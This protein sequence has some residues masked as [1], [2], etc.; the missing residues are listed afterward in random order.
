MVRPPVSEEIA[1][2]VARF[3][4]GGAGPTHT[5][6]T[7]A[8]RV[9]GYVDADPWDPVM[10]T[11]SKEIRVVT[12]IRAATR[13]PIRARELM[14]ALLRDLRAD[15]HFDDGTVTV[16][17]L[18]RAQA[19]FA[20]QEWNLSDQGHLTQKGPINLD[21]GGRPA[22]DEQLRRLQRAGDDPALALGS[23]KDLLEAV[24]KFVLHE[25]DWPLA[26]NP[27]FNQIWYFARE[28]LNLLPQ[29][30][31]GDTP[32]A[33]HIKAILQSAWKIVEQVNELRN[34]QGT[35]HG[36]T[37]PTGVS[38]EMARLV[39]REACSIAEFTLSALDRSKGQPAA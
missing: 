20:E 17:A 5:K 28:R 35:G 19:A 9:G 32:G 23:A 8:I 13:A 7:S 6:L 39:V 34:L 22:L 38:P 25:L 1:A 3:Y 2:T 36:R 14:E 33:K 18:R 10:K 12:V 24:A 30:V 11:P 4:K 15:G 31:P 21:T 26:G 27:D 37:L 29:Q 16:E